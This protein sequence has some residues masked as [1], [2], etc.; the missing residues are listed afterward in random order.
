MPVQI[1]FARLF[2]SIIFGITLERWRARLVRKEWRA[3]RASGKF[4]F[5]PKPGSPPLLDA[6]DQ[7]RIVTAAH[8]EK[9]RILSKAEARVLYT[10]EAAIKKLDVPWRVMV[11]VSLGEI[12]ASP[13]SAAYSAINSKRVDLLVIASDGI[14]ITAIEYQGSGHYQGSAPARDAVKKEALRKAGIR[15]VEVTAEHDIEDIGREIS[16]IAKV[17]QL[18]S[19]PVK[20]QS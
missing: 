12:L 14:P 17:E 18:K 19:Q 7:L 4:S 20:S 6:S 3:K 13:D 5:R 16:R 11:Q 1:L 8:F 2:G 9:R 10:I 15:Y